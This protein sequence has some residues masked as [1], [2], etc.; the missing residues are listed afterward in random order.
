M[1]F[2]SRVKDYVLSCESAGKPGAL[3]T[4]RGLRTPLA[5]RHLLQETEMRPPGNLKRFIN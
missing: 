1:A 5:I 2:A 4:L 3:Q